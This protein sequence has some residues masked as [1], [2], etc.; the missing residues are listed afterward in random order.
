MDL[1]LIF[2]CSHN[3]KSF[4]NLNKK[5]T[6]FEFFLSVYDKASD[7]IECLWKEIEL[8]NMCM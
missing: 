3:S 2:F 1:H 8:Y 7:E 6:A 4:E 5:N